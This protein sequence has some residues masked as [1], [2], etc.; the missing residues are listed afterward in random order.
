MEFERFPRVRRK[1]IVAKITEALRA[2]GARIIREP[3]PGIAPFEYAIELPSGEQRQLVCYAFTAKVYGQGGRPKGEHRFQLKYGSK[4]DRSYELFIDPTRDRSRRKITLLFGVH[5]ELDLF[6]AVDPL[7]HT[8][9]WFSSSVEFKETDLKEARALGWHAWERERTA[10]G[11]RQKQPILDTESFQTEAV[12]A[13]TP[14]YFLHYVE[15]EH[16]ASGLDS[17]ERILVGDQIARNAL[18]GG[19]GHRLER[20]LG[21]SREELLEV[22]SSNP[23]VMVTV[24]GRVAE[25][26][27]GRHLS[28]VPGVSDVRALDQDG[29]P[30]FALTYRRR[31]FRIECKNVRREISPARVDFQKTRVSKGDPCSRYYTASQF[32]VLAACLHPVTSRW[33]FAFCAT[34][35]LAPHKKCE[36]K[37]SDKVLVG[38][39]AWSESL[40]TILDTIG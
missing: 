30:D 23:R 22:L 19:K 12:T 1:E 16:L 39:P 15:F 25:H 10:G 3:D 11:R 13:F 27:L 40:A 18:P 8:P 26:H 7:M 33:D 6:V 20:E 5:L 38:G 21:L 4:F 37:L 34:S 31:P 36:G 9:T 29:P 32:E 35:N 28:A 17:A 2:S 24:R 14:E